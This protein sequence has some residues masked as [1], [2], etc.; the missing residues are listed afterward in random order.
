MCAHIRSF[1]QWTRKRTVVSFSSIRRQIINVSHG[2]V[3]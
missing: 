2:P 3:G 1:G